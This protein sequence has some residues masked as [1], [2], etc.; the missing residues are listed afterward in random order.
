M[1]SHLALEQNVASLL[2]EL[3]SHHHP[4]TLPP[5]QAWGHRT[6]ATKI[7]TDT[8]VFIIFHLLCTIEI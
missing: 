6:R 8:S 2:W 5:G 7:Q 4:F 3:L 1:R